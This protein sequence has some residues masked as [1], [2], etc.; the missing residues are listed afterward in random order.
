[1]PAYTIYG[2]DVALSLTPTKVCKNHQ[3]K[4]G[5]KKDYISVVKNGYMLVEMMPFSKDSTSSVEENNEA[6]P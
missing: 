5:Y 4:F 3:A 1:M 2:Q 6:C